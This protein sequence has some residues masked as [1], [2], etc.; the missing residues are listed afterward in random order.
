MLGLLFGLVLGSYE[1][2]GCIYG[3]SSIRYDQYRGSAISF[4]VYIKSREG[5]FFEGILCSWEFKPFS[6][7][8]S[9]S[10]N[11]SLNTEEGVRLIGSI[12]ERHCRFT[13]TRYTSPLIPYLNPQVRSDNESVTESPR[14]EREVIFVERIDGS[15]DSY[16]PIWLNLECNVDTSDLARI[17]SSDVTVESHLVEFFQFRIK[18][19][20]GNNMGIADLVF[21]V[22]SN[23]FSASQGFQIYSL[24]QKV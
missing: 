2:T 5:S 8:E 6:D 22:N 3:D 24:V 10:I 12:I 16:P 18:I 11:R 21:S 13:W 9:N 17:F 7:S 1:R 4:P 15:L 23:R 14:F 19:N 20:L